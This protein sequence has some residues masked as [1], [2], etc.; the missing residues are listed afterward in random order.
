MTGQSANRPVLWIIVVAAALFLVINLAW[1][2]LS[3]RVLLIVESISERV[4]SIG[5]I[6]VILI[7]AITLAIALAIAF[8]RVDPH[9]WNWG[10]ISQIATAIG[11]I[12]AIIAAAVTYEQN[13]QSTQSNLRRQS[14]IAAMTIVESHY[15]FAAEK[16]V[17]SMGTHTT[18]ATVSERE[19]KEQSNQEAVEELVAQHGLLSAN[20]AFDLTEETDEHSEMRGV[21]RHILER[22]RE[23]IEQANLPCQALDDEF[24]RKFARKEVDIDPCQGP[25]SKD[26]P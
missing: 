19:S 2:G 20:L 22:Y 12:V 25:L 23:D 6:V 13:Q 4:P 14:N 15:R 26:Q 3:K 11:V 10:T 21:A 18:N 16:G 17:G 9:E 1:W 24:V 5:N 8:K 7:V